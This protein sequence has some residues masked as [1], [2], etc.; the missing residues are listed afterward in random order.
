MIVFEGVSARRAPLAL[1][2]LSLAWQAGSHAVVGSRDDGGSLLFE[3][4]A[5]LARPRA[6]RVR[7]LDGAPT[8]AEVRRQVALVPL[9]PP[10]PEAMRV[11]EAL[12]TAAAIRGDSPSDGSARLAVLGVETLV[13][14]AVRS[15]SRAEARAVALAEAVTSTR[16]R[17]LLV[18]EPLVAIDP[19][20][21]TRIP[22]ALR[23]RA[24]SGCAVVVSTGSIRDA[25]D[26][27]DD[28]LFLRGGVARETSVTDALAGPWADGVHLR[29][30]L[31]G[32]ADAQ[33][34]V[35][36]LARDADVESIER[37]GGL[38]RL[39]GRDA[40]A[41]SR[42]ASRAAVEAE[43]DVVELRFDP[44]PSRVARSGNGS[45]RGVS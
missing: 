27:A 3:L 1:S 35:A 7:V 9:E 34:L 22:G 5:G 36:T 44:P 28:L 43:V 17:V 16:V 10:L 19:R 25:V 24:V 23:G 21:A 32:A 29:I 4:V 15:L 8:D 13:D 40:T 2:S 45:T 31:Q 26:L 39:R 12:A 38:L 37:D 6:G 33:A 20:A 18:E 41:L 14:R 11:R 30:L 42:A